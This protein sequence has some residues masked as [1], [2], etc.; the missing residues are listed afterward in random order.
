MPARVFHAL[1][2]DGTGERGLAQIAGVQRGVVHRRQLEE[3]G[4]ARGSYNHRLAAGSLYRVLPSVV[5]VVH[6]LREPLAAE[7]AALLYAGDNVVLSHESAAAL[8]GLTAHPSFVALT[9]ID[10]HVRIRS[11]LVIHHA[12]TLD[13]RDISLRHGLPV[14]SP[15]RT[16]IDCAGRSDMDQLL[17][18][19][20]A[21]NLVTDTAIH[22]AI[23]RCPG[24]KGTG[25]MRRLLEAEQAPGYT[26]SE[27]ERRLKRIIEDANI[28][29]PIFNQPLLGYKPDALWRRQKV[30]VEVDGYRFH[31]HR[32]AFERDRARDAH[33]VAAGYVVVRFTWRQ[34]T[35]RPFEVAAT[36]ARTLARREAEM[37]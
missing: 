37:A 36:I 5:S 19:A 32:Q 31:G 11:Q 13:I 24:R 8:W 10:R 34:L 6:P 18:E 15:A 17:N 12:K 21:Q 4:I 23:D 14:T 28:E 3:L 16:L 33:F 20:R 30:I 35:Q 7:T 25:P 9:V 22:Q 27:A 1:Q 26:R 2:V 29:T